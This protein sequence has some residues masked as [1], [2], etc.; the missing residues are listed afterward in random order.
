MIYSIFN[1]SNGKLIRV[2]QTS[3]IDAQ[4]LELEDYIEGSYLPDEYYVVNKLPIKI[5]SKPSEYYYFDYDT[6]EWVLDIDLL[7]LDV[8]SKRSKLLYASDWTQIPNNPL[9]TEQQAAWATYRQ[10]LRDIS[11]QSG[12]PFN[13]IWPTPPQG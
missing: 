1:K 11:K 6:K 4:L 3:N 10:E 13:V 9:T 8:L 7:T 2:V 12:Y 5:S